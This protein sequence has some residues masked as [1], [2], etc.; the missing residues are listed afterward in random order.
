MAVAAAKA[1]LSYSRTDA[2]T[3]EEI[4]A[5]L[6][7]AGVD[8][9]IDR[10]E[11]QPG[12]SFVARMNEGLESCRYVLLLASA[13]S[14]QSP[15]VSREWMAALAN[16]DIV[17]IPVRL[18][19]VELPALIRDLVWVDLTGD[20]EAGLGQL[21]AI[22]KNESRPALPGVRGGGSTATVD[23]QPRGQGPLQGA[24]RY[25]LRKVA[26]QCLQDSDFL[27]FLFDFEIPAG[28]IGGHSLHERLVN[29]IMTLDTDGLI[30]D[31]ARWL[32][33]ERAACVTSQLRR[34]RAGGINFGGPVA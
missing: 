6:A 23:P 19:K 9:W 17:L 31:F 32:Q 8:F 2:A 26:T 20:R 15:W 1:F 24:T 34:L 12:D 5:A 7:A 30:A 11:V 16:R 22:L 10:R 33:E 18:E 14:L 21:I 3:A 25:E 13:A 29:L 27:A 4:V 28:R